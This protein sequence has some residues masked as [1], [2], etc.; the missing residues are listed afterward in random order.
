MHAQAYINAYT[1]L[2]TD[3]YKYTN[4]YN[5]TD[6]YIYTHRYRYT[7]TNTYYLTLICVYILAGVHTCLLVYMHMN[8]QAYFLSAHTNACIKAQIYG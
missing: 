8:L 4:R 7:H 1:Y 2:N 5:Y 6:K 3:R